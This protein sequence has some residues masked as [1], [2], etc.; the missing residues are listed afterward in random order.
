MNLYL[1]L[2]LKQLHRHFLIKLNYQGTSSTNSAAIAQV[3]KNHDRQ[4]KERKREQEEKNARV[5]SGF[6]NVCSMSV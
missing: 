2:L 5:S 3:S 4:L 1:L 6:H